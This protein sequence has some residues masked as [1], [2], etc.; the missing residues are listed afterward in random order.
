MEMLRG[1]IYTGSQGTIENANSKRQGI[2]D[3][4]RFR[5]NPVSSYKLSLNVKT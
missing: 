3:L 4:F 2:Q 1:E 5:N